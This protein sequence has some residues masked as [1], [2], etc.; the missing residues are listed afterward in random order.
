L[1]SEGWDIV[2]NW[3]SSKE[4]EV[5]PFQKEVWKAFV[6]G[7]NGLLNAPTGSGKTF[8][9]WMPTLI[10]WIN[11]HPDDY[12][13]LENNGLQLLWITPLRALAKD[14]Q[15][16]LQ[17]SLNELGIPWEV[18]RRTGDVSTSVKQKQN[19]KMPE[20]LITT[21]ESVHVLM[22]QKYYARHFKKL[23]TVVVDEWHELL[24]SKRGIQTELALSRLKGLRTELQIWGISATIGNLDQALEVL[25][26]A[27]HQNENSTIIRAKVKKEMK[28]TSV[29][30]DDVETFPWSGHLGLNLLE[31]I[32]PI[33]D[34]HT[35]TLVFTNTRGQAEMWF[36]KIL[37]SRPDYAGQIALHHG[38]LDREVRNWVEQALHEGILK[39]VVCTSSLDLGVDFRP[40]DTVIQIGSPKGVARF[41]QRAGRSGH[42]PGE[43]SSIFFV[44]TNALELIEAAALKNAIDESEMESREP[45]LKPIDVLV[46]YL[47]TLGVSDGFFPED[48]LPEVR[49]T[50]AYQT[51][52]DDEWEWLL[53][54]ITTGGRSLG[55]YPEYSK[56]TIDEDGLYKVIDRRIARRHRMS[57]GTI[58]SDSMMRV[59]YLTGGNL[60]NIEETFIASLNIGDKF[61]FAGRNLELVQLKEMVA[62]VRRAKGT[63]SKVP[64]W[65]GGRMSLSSNMSK[66][67]RRTMQDAIA[68]DTGMIELE[69]I[70]PILD[71]Q[72]DW[73][74]LPNENQFLIEKSYS[75]EG[76]HVFFFPFEG[77]YVHEGMSALIA[78][79]ISKM[80]PISFSIAMNDYGF[81]LL[82]DQDIPIEE[83]LENNVLSPE[84]LMDDISASMND[85]ELA[86][87][88][89][90]EIGQ[91]AGLVF[92][93]FPGEQ[94]KTKHLRMSTSLMFDVFTEYEPGHLLIQQ[95][96]DEVMFFQLDEIRLTKVLMKIQDQEIVVNHTERFTPY[97]FPIFVDRLR[98]K[99]SSEKLIDRVRKMQLQ[100]KKHVK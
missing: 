3:F 82:S 71:V 41:M 15:S 89:F 16:A 74:I 32:T 83:A 72:K 49:K 4:W 57:I 55:K 33:I 13:K 90:W 17:T 70:E 68:G 11:E 96:F 46:Q 88:K 12:Q 14:I 8:A 94:R 47:V 54:F 84:N 5:F 81:E 51:L 66:I 40:V 37:E 61:W 67:L 35:S 97:A 63:K 100:L 76:C 6:E 24:G 10:K 22:A 99:L 62:Y 92:H 98:G 38:S 43:V 73:S 80:K 19:R 45:I 75:R 50:F 93:G 30:P 2:E 87:R 52:Q 27:D 95:A 79:R 59:K 18:G 44:P 42:R 60:G 39:A 58:S 86:K 64:S 65:Q 26:G 25:L 77:R 23:N 69:T 78:H 9:L 36:Q 53:T 91:V 28:V 48:I 85:S 21:P 29:L 31:K 34:S 20:V 56:V 7:N 1:K